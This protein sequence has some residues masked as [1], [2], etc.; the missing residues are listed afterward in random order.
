M[1]VIRIVGVIGIV[2]GLFI[3]LDCLAGS[4]LVG[5]G[6]KGAGWWARVLQ[7]MFSPHGA[8]AGTVIGIACVSGGLLLLLQPR[9]T[10]LAGGVAVAMVVLVLAAVACG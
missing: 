4:T 1:F 8:L 6:V 10:W 5:P 7:T 3:L 9:R 2:F